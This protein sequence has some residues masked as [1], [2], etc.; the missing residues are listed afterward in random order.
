MNKLE[1][2]E[3]ITANLENLTTEELRF[4]ENLLNQ[5]TSYLKLKNAQDNLSNDNDDPLV[6]LRNSDFIGCFSGEPDLAEKSEQ[7]V[8]DIILN[9]SENIISSEIT[10]IAEK[11]PVFEFLKDEPDIY[12]LEDGEAI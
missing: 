3:R 11:S 6:E 7:I 12:T 10:K 4:I 9:L 8:R 5:F 1:I 2:K